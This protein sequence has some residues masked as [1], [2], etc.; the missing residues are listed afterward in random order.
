MATPATP[1]SPNQDWAVQAAD[2]IDR[3]VTGLGDKTTRPLTAIAAGIVYGLVA[4]AAGLALFVLIA[5][6]LVRIGVNYIPI[7]PHERVVW[8]TEAGLGGIFTLG[9][10]FLWRK[11]RPKQA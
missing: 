3:V 2:T 4:A 9:G 1:A 7:E 10:L 8:V 5:V 11:R 6:A